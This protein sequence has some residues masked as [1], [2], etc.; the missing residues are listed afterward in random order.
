MSQQNTAMLVL[1][2]GNL[3]IFTGC[4]NAGAGEQ[5]NMEES[6]TNADGEVRLPEASWRFVQVEQV[7]AKKSAAILRTP[8]RVAFRDGAVSK[9]GAPM[10]GRVEQVPADHARIDRKDGNASIA[11]VQDEAADMERVVDRVGR[12]LKEAAGD[13]DRKLLRGDVD[14]GRPGAEDP[15]RLIPRPGRGRECQRQQNNPIVRVRPTASVNN[16]PAR[17]PLD[18]SWPASP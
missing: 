7:S 10:Q 8:A 11:V 12:P 9:V 16:N 6:V 5:L 17:A 2:L 13:L 4:S 14:R 15:C 18:A 1:L 3:L